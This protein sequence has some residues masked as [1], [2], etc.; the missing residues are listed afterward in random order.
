M[1]LASGTKLGPYEI[2]SPL[3]AGGMG[4]VYR[5][6]DARLGR[7]VAIKVL[8]AESTRNAESLLRFEQEAKAASAL[9]HPNI[10]TVY[11]IGEAEG[12][13]YI[14]TE[15][16]E[17]QTLRY[18]APDSRPLLRA[19]EIAL[20]TANALAAA[21]AAGIVHRD[22]KPENLMLRPD[23][24]VKVLDF[25]LAKLAE[26]SVMAAR[27]DPQ[28]PTAAT[29]LTQ[30]GRVMGACEIYISWSWVPLPK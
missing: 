12:T 4:E 15:F 19:V 29:G 18:L 23:G 2:L 30:V 9:N 24:Y 10:L 25:G 3:G 13:R 27:E 1:T 6:R 22:I 28:A 17:G 11:D 5:A 8:P 14:A 26:P 7:T 16:V 20:Q 21:H